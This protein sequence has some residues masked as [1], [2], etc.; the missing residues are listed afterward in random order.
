MYKILARVFASRLQKMLPD[1][2]SLTQG[3][4]INGRQMLDGV[5]VA[6]ECIH[7]RNLHKRLGLICKLDLEKAYNW[8][9]WDFLDYLIGRMGF[10]NRWRRWIMECVSST[11]FFW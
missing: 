8:V 10:G 5:L 6:N 2:I 1:L 4:F 3:A 9:D 7:C 11:H